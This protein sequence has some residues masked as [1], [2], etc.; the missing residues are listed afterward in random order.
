MKILKEKRQK[1]TVSLEIEAS[2]ETIEQG[3]KKVF[4]DVVKTAKVH[5][6]RQ[7]KVPQHIFEKHYGRE[8]L[9]KD[10][11]SEAV[12]MAYVKA[13]QENKLDV[14]DYPKN[15]SIGDYKENAPIT[16]TCDVDVKP[17][18][19]VDKYKG[20]KVEKEKLNNKFDKYKFYRNNKLIYE[21]FINWSKEEQNI[22]SEKNNLTQIITYGSPNLYDLNSE[23]NKI[24]YKEE[25]TNG[26]NNFVIR[27]YSITLIE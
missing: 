25:L 12:N 27:P 13:I 2:V 16:F 15:L 8:M 22:I 11:I 24:Y 17:E 7:G 10:G 14:V 3:I 26:Q 20:L 4:R 19:R 9:L 21:C 23:K 5:G 1:N 6:F 18:I